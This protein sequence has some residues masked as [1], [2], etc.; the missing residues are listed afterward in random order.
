MSCA[1]VFKEISEKLTEQEKYNYEFGKY[2]ADIC[3]YIFLVGTDNYEAML[4]GIKEKNYD[5]QKVFMMK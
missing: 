1:P 5:E 2:M 4:K 3:D